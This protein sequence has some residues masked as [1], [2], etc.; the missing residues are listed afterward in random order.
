ME[1]ITFSTIEYASGEILLQYLKRVAKINKKEDSLGASLSTH[2]NSI[3]VA[4]GYQNWSVLHKNLGGRSS[5]QVGG[6]VN[7]I[8]QHKNLGRKVEIMSKR[9]VNVK[10]ATQEMQDWA[11]TKYT[12]LVEFAYYDSESPNGYSWPEVD[13]ALELSEEFGGKFPDELIEQVGYDLDASEGPWGLE[14]YGDD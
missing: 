11:R 5:Y 12:P 4:L 10:D 13:M 7:R 3:A 8:L 2:Q 6:V 1:T 14:D 9:T